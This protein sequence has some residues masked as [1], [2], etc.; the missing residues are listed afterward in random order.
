MKGTKKRTETITFRISPLEK[1]KIF[2]FCLDR[3]MP[4]SAIIRE[5]IRKIIK[6]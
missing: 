4:V 5:Q 1:Q 6:K 2:R 3:D